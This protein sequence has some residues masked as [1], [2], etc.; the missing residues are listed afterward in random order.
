MHDLDHKQ[1][2]TF[3]QDAQRRRRL[4][5][6]DNR[7]EV[8]LPEGIALR[9]QYR[10]QQHGS[11]SFF[12]LKESGRC[13]AWIYVFRPHMAP[14]LALHKSTQGNGLGCR[15]RDLGWD[16]DNKGL[17]VCGP[18]R[19]SSSLF[20][21]FLCFWFCF[22]LLCFV[23]LATSFSIFVALAV[24]ELAMYTRLA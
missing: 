8:A 14:S 11:G 12:Q 17:S 4:T 7:V 19:C 18:R 1:T 16:Q 10:I 9:A 2:G 3:D 24:L 6:A 15:P 21:S 22:V 20:L 13:S 5:S 23:L